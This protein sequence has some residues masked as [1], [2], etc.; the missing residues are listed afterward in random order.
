MKLLPLARLWIAGCCLAF[1]GVPLSAGFTFERGAPEA[2]GVS[3]AKMLRFIEELDSK[4]DGMHSV[5]VVRHGKV[6]AEGWW[7]PYRPESRHVMFSLSKSFASTAVGLAQAEGKLSVDDTVV[8]FFPDL[9]PKDP[10]GNLKA[11]RVRDLL[12]MSTGQHNEDIARFDYQSEDAVKAFLAIPVAHKPGTHFVYNTPATFMLSA[13]VQKVAGQPLLEYLRPRLFEP[14]GIENPTWDSGKSGVN[15]G[16]FGLSVRTEDIAR[17]G[18]LYLQ[19]GQWRGKQLLPAAWVA[20]ATSR[21][22][23]NGSNPDSDWDQGYGYQFWR[24]R[25]N[26]FRG[27]GAFGQYCVVMPDQDTVLAITSGVK[28]MQAVLNIA[29]A[30]L[31]PALENSALP[32]DAPAHSALAAKLKSLSLR[33]VQHQPASTQ[34]RSE[35]SGKKFMFP[36]NPQKLEAVTL[37]GNTAT[38][39]IDGADRTF[40]LNP[41]FNGWTAPSKFAFDLMAEQPASASG[42]WNGNV[43]TLKLAFTESPALLTLRMA[44]ATEAGKGSVAVDPEFGAVFGPS[45]RK[46]LVGRAD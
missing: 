32:I 7:T 38:L 12:A 4:I 30:A 14:L 43:F 26:A 18:Q 37:S 35:I 42:G 40:S 5:M 33:P 8:S 1:L 19:K 39:R 10:S 41:N 25:H 24:S 15:L 29:W 21:Q 28:D 9:A 22:A 3:S 46:Q 36:E 20:A 23:S 11:M 31:L 16:G 6:I 34:T 17:L 27:D 45:S 2:N 44:F 13:I